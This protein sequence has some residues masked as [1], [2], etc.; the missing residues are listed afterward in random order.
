LFD[1]K[2][3]WARAVLVSLGSTNGSIF[4]ILPQFL[5]SKTTSH[6]SEIALDYLDDP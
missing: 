2:K 3:R 6:F 4:L 1:N 5:V